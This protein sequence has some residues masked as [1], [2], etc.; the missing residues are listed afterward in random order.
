MASQAEQVLS[1]S[2]RLVNGRSA[3]PS[4]EVE[5]GC[6]AILPDELNFAGGSQGSAAPECGGAQQPR[7]LG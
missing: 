4:R 2:L 5:G 6:S 7:R 3:V 1:L